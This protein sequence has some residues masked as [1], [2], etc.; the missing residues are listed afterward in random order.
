MNSGLMSAVSTLGR[1]ERIPVAVPDNFI[2]I[3][4]G[5]IRVVAGTSVTRV[6]TP[7]I[8][9]CAAP[10]SGTRQPILSVTYFGTRRAG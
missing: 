6:W 3:S 2:A 4:S 1:E 10:Y 9:A 5:M 8:V 7:V